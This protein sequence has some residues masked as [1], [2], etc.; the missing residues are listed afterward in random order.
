MS[1]SCHPT[2]SKSDRPTLLQM[3][4]EERRKEKEALWKATFPGTSGALDKDRILLDF[5]SEI[6]LASSAQ[7]NNAS[8]FDEDN[9]SVIT[10]NVQDILS[11]TIG[12]ENEITEDP[13]RTVL[14]SEPCGSFMDELQESQL[15]D[16]STGLNK[17][18]RATTRIRSFLKNPEHD[19]V[20]E[21]TKSS[22]RAERKNKRD[23][24][25]NQMR[26]MTSELDVTDG[27]SFEESNKQRG[28]ANQGQTEILTNNT[29]SDNATSE[30]SIPQIT[31]TNVEGTTATKPQSP[32]PESN[33]PQAASTPTNPTNVKT[34]SENHVSGA[35]Q[36]GRGS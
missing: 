24:K 1:N 36:P 6:T 13:E 31:I 2:N 33:P 25:R 5:N 15:I 22:M 35:T 3:V 34:G 23:M 29:P 26:N 4:N 27:T 16:Q 11:S 7:Q 12:Q 17:S 14:R 20:V 30:G 21:K 19:D 18:H 28:D 8:V 10:T 9:D 32:N